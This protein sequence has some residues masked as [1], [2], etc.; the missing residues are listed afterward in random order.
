[1]SMNKR[2]VTGDATFWDRFSLSPAV[3]G[4]SRPQRTYTMKYVSRALGVATF[5]SALGLAGLAAQPAFAQDRSTNGWRGTTAH[6]GTWHD[7]DD[8]GSFRDRDDRF[9]D[10]DDRVGFRDRDDRFRDRDDRVGFRDRDDRFRD[11]DDRWGW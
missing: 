10:R 5:A 11:R 8:R 1:M 9:R 2:T 4:R 6:T 3:R 7:R